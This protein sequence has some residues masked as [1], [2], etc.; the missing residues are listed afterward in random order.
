MRVSRLSV[1]HCQLLYIS[2]LVN[3]EPLSFKTPMKAQMRT[4]GQVVGVSSKSEA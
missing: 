3:P 4:E 2:A 1:V